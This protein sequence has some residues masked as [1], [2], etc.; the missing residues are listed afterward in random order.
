MIQFM[1]G[2]ETHRTSSSAVLSEGQPF[3][4][5]DTN[6]LYI[7]NGTSELR[8][9]HSIVT[10]NFLPAMNFRESSVLS[11]Y[12]E[13]D[14]EVSKLLN[15]NDNV[16]LSMGVVEWQQTNRITINTYTSSNN[17]QVGWPNGSSAIT[18]G[19]GGIVGAAQRCIYA[20]L[21][22]VNNSSSGVVWSFPW[23]NDTS[24]NTFRIWPKPFG[25]DSTLE[26]RTF[27]FYYFVLSCFNSM[28]QG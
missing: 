2:A 26:S 28:G 11:G 14:G 21:V 4:E 12:Y 15:C 25:V 20:H 23:E 9:L 17:N 19:N 16:F 3:Y 6:K 18:P 27:Y 1:R 10:D 8:Y 7:G 22:P 13:W 24:R 5:T